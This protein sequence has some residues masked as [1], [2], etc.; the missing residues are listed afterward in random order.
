MIK[1]ITGRFQHNSS[2]MRPCFG[3]TKL[4]KLPKFEKSM[5]SE[6]ILTSWFSIRF[7]LELPKKKIFS[8]LSNFFFFW[9]HD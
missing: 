2:T 5:F 7:H 3:D 1:N 8:D 6:L 4:E 9:C